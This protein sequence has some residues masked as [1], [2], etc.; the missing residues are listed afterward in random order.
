MLA[1]SHQPDSHPV[2]EILL[3]HRDFSWLCLCLYK[4]LLQC[5]NID[6]A[7]KVALHL[8]SLSQHICKAAK[9]ALLTLV[10]VPILHNYASCHWEAVPDTSGS[11]QQFCFVDDVIFIVMGMILQFLE[12]C[13]NSKAL[14][15][16]HGGWK[17][18]NKLLDQIVGCENTNS[19]VLPLLLDMTRLL[20][21]KTLPTL[22]HSSSVNIVKPISNHPV[23]NEHRNE[24]SSTA[25]PS[26]VRS[27]FRGISF[28]WSSD[29]KRLKGTRDRSTSMDSNTI[30]NIRTNSF[31]SSVHVDETAV[32]VVEI[33]KFIQTALG[34]TGASAH[35]LTKDKLR[36]TLSFVR[37]VSVAE[38]T[39]SD[40][41]ILTGKKK[42]KLSETSGYRSTSLEHLDP[43]PDKASNHSLSSSIIYTTDNL[44]LPGET[45]FMKWKKLT[46]FWDIVG[47][48]VPA[49]GELC[50]VF[51]DMNG[52]YVALKLLNLISMDMSSYFDSEIDFTH[53]TIEQSFNESFQK[54]TSLQSSCE[55]LTDSGKREE[56]KT[57]KRVPSR[58]NS[59]PKMS[60]SA[61]GQKSSLKKTASLDDL[62]SEAFNI[63][64]LKPNPPADS[65]ID[66]PESVVDIEIQQRVLEQKLHLF[67]S[68]LRICLFCAK[69]KEQ[70][71]KNIWLFEVQSSR[72][73]N[74]VKC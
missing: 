25:Q 51:L 7:L 68:C 60:Y 40:T 20:S 11:S 5:N 1:S 8:Q 6:L 36:K 19:G 64:F 42:R 65:A 12:E 63:S 41:E 39:D 50:S 49:D 62:L 29:K 17:V 59:M 32:Y 72:F 61:Q 4:P 48:A 22:S 18:L 24:P 43:S 23:E 71:R 44:Q 52:F 3:Q 67:T 13:N 37:A 58:L 33:K 34:L 16:R 10:L 69:N 70:V 31:P 2:E 53:T 73:L 38:S 45:E 74:R 28:S 57:L 26:G 66:T 14:F 30:K 55:G 15:I 56:D 27:F 47:R 46:D 54:S 9:S 21:S 35:D